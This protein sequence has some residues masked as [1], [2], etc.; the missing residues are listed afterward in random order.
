M[1]FMPFKYNMSVGNYLKRVVPNS[2]IDIDCRLCQEQA[3]M[4][5]TLPGHIILVLVQTG[6]HGLCS[7]LCL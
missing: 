2:D 1:C 5:V 3:N 4:R 7:W 6:Y